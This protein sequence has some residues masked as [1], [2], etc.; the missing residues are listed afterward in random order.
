MLSEFMPEHAL[1]IIVYILSSCTI[2]GGQSWDGIVGVG[3]FMFEYSKD[4]ITL[5]ILITDI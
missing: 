5:H 2:I 1:G 3:D 4:M